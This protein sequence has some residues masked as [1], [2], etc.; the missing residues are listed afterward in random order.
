[1]VSTG[2]QVGGVSA[3]WR[4]SSALTQ[5]V[6]LIVVAAL[7][8]TAGSLLVVA[9]PIES[10]R[11]APSGALTFAQIEGFW[12]LAG[13][14]PSVAATAAAI[15]GAEAGFNPGAIQQ[16]VAYCGAGANKTG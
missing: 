13:G 16:G 11:A 5:A 8:I 15:T 9:G 6:R 1:M 4:R 2:R 3:N 7:F 10:A 14:P 12:V